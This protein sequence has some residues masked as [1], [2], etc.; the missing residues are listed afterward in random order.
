MFLDSSKRTSGTTQRGPRAG[1][2]SSRGGPR[3]V[4][5]GAGGGADGGSPSSK[6]HFKGMT[7]ATANGKLGF[8][9]TSKASVSPYSFFYPSDVVSNM[10][11]ISA[12]LDP[13]TL[14]GFQDR[15]KTRLL[16][17]E[18]FN[19]YAAVFEQFKSSNL[20]TVHKAFAQNVRE[21]GMLT[22][23]LY[24]SA[25]VSV[26]VTDRNVIDRSFDLF[27]PHKE[28]AVDYREVI[29]AVEV[30]VNGPNKALTMKECFKLF[31]PSDCGYIIQPGLREIKIQRSETDGINHL[32]VKALLE[33]FDELQREENERLAKENTKKKGKRAKKAEKGKP[34][35]VPPHSPKIHLSF[36]EFCG[37][38]TS[39]ALLVQAFLTPIL[40]TMEMVYARNRKVLPKKE[41]LSVALA[42]PE[43]TPAAAGTA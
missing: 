12:A 38:M 34:L 2:S 28:N 35:E 18:Y 3:A 9:E 22:R 23:E 25:L 37:F 40:L 19:Q 4:V 32:M 30:I 27:D 8:L 21:D 15:K 26:G 36:E 39:R 33:I 17:R 1:V 24:S 42:V 20:S 14:P 29:A 6:Y 5:V 13:E 11:V 16:K 10:P 7:V 43:A 41:E 31:D